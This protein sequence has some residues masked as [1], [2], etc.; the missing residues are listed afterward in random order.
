[1]PTS[2]ETWKNTGTAGSSRRLQGPRRPHA[3]E[4][5]DGRG[6]VRRHEANI[7]RGLRILGERARRA[8]MAARRPKESKLALRAPRSSDAAARAV[9]VYDTRNAA[10]NP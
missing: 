9:E 8:R 10:T 6:G 7:R 3:H 5:G 2:R 1:M 4:A